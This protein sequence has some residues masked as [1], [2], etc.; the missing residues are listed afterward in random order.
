MAM[1]V[2]MS[3]APNRA[4][5]VRQAAGT[6]VL[7]GPGGM[8]RHPERFEDGPP[9]LRVLR[10]VPHLGRP[11]LDRDGTPVVMVTPAD[12]PSQAQTAG[13]AAGACLRHTLAGYGDTTRW[14]STF[15]TPGAAAAAALAVLASVSECTCPK[16]LAV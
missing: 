12:R 7:A 14:F 16:S 10:R 6:V 5:A 8:T 3:V 2:V 15:A 11:A 4:A 9:E 1:V 13:S